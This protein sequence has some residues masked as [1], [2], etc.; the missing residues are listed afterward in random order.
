[1]SSVVNSGYGSHW[2]K[3]AS[4]NIS[5]LYCLDEQLANIYVNEKINLNECMCNLISTANIVI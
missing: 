5:F 4:K 2:V 1:M 3:V